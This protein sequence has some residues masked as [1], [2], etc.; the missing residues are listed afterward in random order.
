MGL[1]T[2]QSAIVGT[3]VAGTGAVVPG[4]EPAGEVAEVGAGV[5]GIAAGDR[6]AVHLAIGDGYCEF[7]RGGYFMLCPALKVVGFDVDGG[8]ADYLVVPARNCL[9]LPDEIGFVAGALM[10]DMIGSQYHTQKTMGIRGGQ[11]VAVFGL[12]P[13]G[14]AAVMVA[15]AFGAD[16]IAV[17]LLDERLKIAESIGA[18]RTVNSGSVNPVEVIREATSGRGVDAAIDCS[19]APPAQN[20][21]LDVAAKLG[22]VAFVGESRKTEINPS[23]QIIR[24]LLTVTGGWYFPSSEWDEIVRLVVDRQIPV[25]ELV[26]HRFPITDAPE[27][28]RA[29]DQR[30]TEKA[31]FTWD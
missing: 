16:V 18:G 20:A 28:F 3:D 6:V 31:V 10:T 24:K 19:G 29:F 17:D 1:Y 11:T 30:E 22:A 8:D 2:G 7:C 23:D 14:G 9:K 27:A 26:T 21:A 5:E 25:E 13:M 12:G 15:K 4:H